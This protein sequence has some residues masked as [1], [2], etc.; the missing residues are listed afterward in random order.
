MSTGMI[1]TLASVGVLL[2]VGVKVWWLMSWIKKQ[3]NVEK[4]DE[5]SE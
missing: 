3:E 1:I 5:R 2:L 4:G